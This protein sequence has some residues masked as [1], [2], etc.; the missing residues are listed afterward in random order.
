[1]KNEHHERRLIM[2]ERRTAMPIGSTITEQNRADVTFGSSLPGF[3]SGSS[4]CERVV[5]TPYL[6]GIAAIQYAN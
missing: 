5:Q 2:G 1:M 6:S 3:F 4:R